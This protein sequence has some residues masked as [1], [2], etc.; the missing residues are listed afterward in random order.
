MYYNNG[1]HHTYSTP[2]FLDPPPEFLVLHVP[3]LAGAEHNC[4]DYH[5]HAR[6]HV[7]QCCIP[8]TAVV[9]QLLIDVPLITIIKNLF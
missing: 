4:C 7:Q 8:C 5:M 6:V 2:W 1:V 9:V 3:S